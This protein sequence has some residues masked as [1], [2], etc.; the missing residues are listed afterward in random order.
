MK[1]LSFQRPAALVALLASAAAC[2]TNAPP[3]PDAAL[4]PLRG[5]FLS[6]AGQA[7]FVAGIDAREKHAA[8]GS[9]RLEAKPHAPA[10]AGTLMQHASIA[11]W[12]GKRVRFSAYTKSQDL[13]DWAGLWMRITR[14]GGA[15]AF[16]NMQER[17][18]R[19]TTPWTKHDVV[20]DVA[21][22]ATSLDFGLLQS[23]AGT[24]WIDDATLEVVGNDV[25]TTNLDRRAFVLENGD[26]ERPGSEPE[27]WSLD[28]PA[29]HELA[30][31]VV[32]DEHHGGSASMKVASKN[33]EPSGIGGVVQYVRSDRWL[34]KRVR[35]AAW[36]KGLGALHVA[37][38]P[39][40]AALYH[41]GLTQGG[42]ELEAAAWRECAVVLDVPAAS[43]AFEIG[44]WTRRAAPM[45]VDDVRIEEVSA[46]APVT[47]PRV[48]PPPF[49][50]GDFEARGVRGGRIEGW[51]MSGGSRNLYAGVI[52]GTERHGGAASLRFA[53]TV[54]S[55]PGYGTFMQHFSARPFHGKRVR[56][57]AFVKGRGIDGRGDLW[58]RVQSDTSPG[59]GAGLGGGAC[60]LENDF[61]WKP[62]VIVFDVSDEGSA[63][64]VGVGLDPHGTIWLDDV[65]FEEVGLDVALTHPQRP[66]QL[67]GGS[68]E[69]ALSRYWFLSG[70]GQSE[71]EAVLDAAEH[72][73]GVSS[74]RLRAK[75]ATSP[76]ASARY[77][78]WMTAVE[79][80]DYRGKRVRVSAQVKGTGITARGDMWMRVQGPT[81]PSDGPGLGGGRC[82]LSGD[83]A[84]K[85]CIMVIDVPLDGERI[86]VGVG[87]AGPGTLF[88]D[89]VHLDVVPLDVST[90][91][92]LRDLGALQNMELEP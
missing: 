20:L 90:T 55:P 34:G 49:R 72:A 69:G 32:H 92:S 8:L 77:G 58:L 2:T 85:S 26:F 36:M 27:G 23:G 46:D 28:G 80:G 33:G 40:G 79:A 41:P 45:W 63:I 24:S 51:F 22:D 31:T 86:E 29:G 47:S 9:G 6:G 81:S 1:T 61:D 66:R 5:W 54:D 43:D 50:N 59:D 83:F 60:G 84:W 75:T 91:A 48:E 44:V 78:T 88:V 53:P 76:G 16:D 15:V 57:S 67:E 56:M 73:V 12:R 4:Q 3:V 89:D 11:A 74:V 30:A 37:T 18:L 25:A 64:Q 19:S 52:D 21:A 38:L 35:V 65:R 13:A 17:P 70:G 14:K 10:G 87:L 39:A 68:F 7:S 42:C 82:G 62:C 71:Y